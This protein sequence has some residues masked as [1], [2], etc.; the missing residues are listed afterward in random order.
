MTKPRAIQWLEVQTGQTID[1]EPD[2]SQ[3]RHVSVRLTK[4]LGARLDTMATERDIK[5]SQLIRELLSE[6]IAT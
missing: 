5:V 3:D 4:E 2:T 1:Y 6:A